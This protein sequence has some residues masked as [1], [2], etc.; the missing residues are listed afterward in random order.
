M[1]PVDISIL[2]GMALASH[3]LSTLIIR[4][5]IPKLK[6]GDAPATGDGALPESTKGRVFDLG[7][8]GFWIGLC[9]TLLIFILVSAQQFSALAII[10]GVKQFVRSDKI[11]QNPS[12]YLLGTLCNLTI[13][14][15]F[16]LT[17]NQLTA[18]Y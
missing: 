16:A 1:N 18:L 5:G 13:A 7:S 9:E 6:S 12:Y 3:I 14:T 2:V 17:A 15:L 8:T 11:Q 4:L 10:I